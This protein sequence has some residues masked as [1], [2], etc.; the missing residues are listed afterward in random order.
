MTTQTGFFLS[1]PVDG[2]VNP[3]TNYLAD[4]TT[5]EEARMDAELAG[6]ESFV[7][8]GYETMDTVYATLYQIAPNGGLA[9]SECFTID[10]PE[11]L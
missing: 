5:L 1:V 4:A 3:I 9:H 8:A 10:G 7:L 6:M 2:Q 11:A